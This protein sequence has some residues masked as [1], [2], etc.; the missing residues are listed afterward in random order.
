MSVIKPRR[1]AEVKTLAAV[2]LWLALWNSL[3]LVQAILFWDTLAGYQ[4]RGGSLYLAVSGGVWAAIGFI[5]GWAAW[6]GKPWAWG[7]T[8]GAAA[9]YGSWVWFDRFILQ[10]PHGNEPFVQALTIVMLLFVLLLL[11]SGKIRDFYHDR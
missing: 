5:L 4:M 7:A 9:G 8:L 1:P 2:I 11:F 3:R 6:Q 10:K